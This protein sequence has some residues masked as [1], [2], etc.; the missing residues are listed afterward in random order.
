MRIRIKF[1]VGL[2]L[3]V[4]SWFGGEQGHAGESPVV[5]L[6]TPP[7]CGIFSV[8]DLAG[9]FQGLLKR[10][11]DAGVALSLDYKGEVFGNFTGDR[12]PPSMRDF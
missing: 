3:L 11:S 4:S 2:F 6:S 7:V 10:A 9:K 5:S 12:G 8:D 1:A